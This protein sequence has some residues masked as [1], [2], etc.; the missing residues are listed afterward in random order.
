MSS[1]QSVLSATNVVAGYTSRPSINAVSLE[2]FKGS[3]AL[4][5]TGASG[6]GKTTLSHTLYGL[7]KPA[8]GRVSFN[9]QPVHKLKLGNKKKF[10]AAVG[11][12]AQ[13]GFFGLDT[14][15]TVRK[16]VE[17][18]LKRARKAGRASGESVDQILETMFLEPRFKERKLRTLSGGERQRLS[19]ALALVSRPDVLILDEPTTALDATL[20]DKVSARLRDL[21]AEREIGLLVFSHDLNLLSRLCSQVH[22]LADGQFVE[23]GTPRDL[24]T[25]PQHPATVEMAQAYPEAVRALRALDA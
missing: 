3:P 14:E 2:L 1:K 24:L 7:L 10:E 11:R 15:F 6:V 20:K 12:V 13:N 17:D 19:I 21:V 18:E 16:V 8:G 25:N 4:G 9:G 22:V 5:I 23:T